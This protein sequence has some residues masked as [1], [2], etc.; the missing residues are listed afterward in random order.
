MKNYKVAQTIPNSNV[1]SN[2]N[3]AQVTIPNIKD[4]FGGKNLSSITNQVITILLTLIVVAAVIVIILSGFRMITGGGNP[5]QIAKSKKAIIWAV[6]GI[7]V[8][9]MSFAIISIIQNLL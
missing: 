6:V 9:F 2:G 5:D 8:A 7:V 1:P 3:N 4:P